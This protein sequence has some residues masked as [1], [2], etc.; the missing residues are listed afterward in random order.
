MSLEVLGT[1]LTTSDAHFYV[2]GCIEHFLTHVLLCQKSECVHL[3]I[4]STLAG[5]D[6]IHKTQVVSTILIKCY[7]SSQTPLSR[8]LLWQIRTQFCIFHLFKNWLNPTQIKHHSCSIRWVFDTRFHLELVM[9][10]NGQS[11]VELV[12]FMVC[13]VAPAVIVLNPWQYL[14]EEPSSKC[15]QYLF[16]VNT[17]DWNLNTHW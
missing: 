9:R 15:A 6:W 12:T 5:N 16:I 13:S 2:L 11:T 4:Y 1:L 7:F 3:C 17:V 10:L 14:A 8:C